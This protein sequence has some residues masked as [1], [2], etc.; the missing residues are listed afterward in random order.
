M[1]EISE[2]KYGEEGSDLCSFCLTDHFRSLNKVI[3]LLVRLSYYIE[4]TTCT[5]THTQ[6]L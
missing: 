1:E 2:N 4:G 6:I 5:F 3:V